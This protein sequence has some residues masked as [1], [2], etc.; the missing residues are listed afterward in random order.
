MKNIKGQQDVNFYQII[1]ITKNR[2]VLILRVEKDK[3]F[4]P[5]GLLP[6]HISQV[7]FTY[8]KLYVAAL[9]IKVTTSWHTND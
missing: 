9:Y 7:H 4:S 3:Y 8:S 1:L 6:R 2:K 5:S